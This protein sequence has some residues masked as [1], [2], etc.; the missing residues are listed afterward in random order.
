MTLR[1]VHELSPQGL[2]PHRDCPVWQRREAGSEAGS[3]GR[4]RSP[5]RSERA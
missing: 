1:E 5:A 2:A 3:A 4:E